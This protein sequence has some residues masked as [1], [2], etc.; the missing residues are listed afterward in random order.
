MK[1]DAQG[2]M[3]I[4]SN[5]VNRSCV[6]C[7]DDYPRLCFCDAGVSF[8]SA[9]IR[10][11]DAQIASNLERDMGLKIKTLYARPSLSVNWGYM[12]YDFDDFLSFHR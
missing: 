1:Y 2:V 8:V 3:K 5:D 12:T 4:F 10:S 11:M 9:V 6:W 7:F